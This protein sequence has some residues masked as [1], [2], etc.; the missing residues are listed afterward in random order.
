MRPARAANAMAVLGGA[1]L[2]LTSQPALGARGDRRFAGCKSS[3]ETARKLEAGGHLCEAQALYLACFKANCG[4]TLE[5]RCLGKYVSLVGEIPTVMPVATDEAGRIR[6]DVQVNVDG[7]P[8]ASQTDGRA[9]PVDPGAHRF[10]FAT[11]QGIFAIRDVVL[12][13][14]EHYRRIHVGA[15]VVR[16]ASMVPRAPPSAAAPPAGRSGSAA[17]SA[18]PGASGQAP[19]LA[20]G[21]SSQALSST[22]SATQPAAD[23]AVMSAGAGVDVMLQIVSAYVFRGYNV[24]QS[25]SQHDQ[26]MALLGRLIWDMPRTDL[27]LGY[28]TAYQL[29]GDN[30][31]HDIEVGLGAEQVAFADYDWEITSHLTVTPEIAVVAYPAAQDFPLFLEGSAEAQVTAPVDVTLYAGYFAAVRPGPLSETH[32]YVRPVVEKEIDLTRRFKLSIDAGAGVK[33]FQ[34]NPGAIHSNM[35]DVLANTAVA[36]AF[37]S[38]LSATAAVGLAWTNLEARQDASTGRVITPTLG[39]EYVPVATLGVEGDW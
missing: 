27:S 23:A 21:G 22:P 17:G 32:F 39:D 11:T 33:F 28:S 29:T 20:P 24:F 37:N 8:M 35:F 6:V 4:A 30:V 9:F 12:H 1:A 10:T 16:P 2:F 38:A 18:A 19:S 34:S 7:R 13:R 36:Y 31:S 5:D 15:A 3:Y 26:N 25:T 14:G